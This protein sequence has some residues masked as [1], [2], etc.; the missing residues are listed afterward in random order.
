MR[1]IAVA[2]VLAGLLAV[3]AAAEYPD[4]PVRLIVP[5]AAGSATDTVARILGLELGKELGQQIVIDNR[6]G[7]ALTIGLDLTTKAEPDGYT[8][9]MGPIGALAITR[10]MV[11]KLPNAIE[12]DLQPVALAT[13]GHLLLAVCPTLPFKSVAELIAFAKENPGKLLNASS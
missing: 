2:L 5:Q 11:A 9:C 10:H 1:S 3:P 4:K 13:R 7:G 8:I 12:R 6:P